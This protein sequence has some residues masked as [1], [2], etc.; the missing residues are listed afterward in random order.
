MKK[1]LILSTFFLSTILLNTGFAQSKYIDSLSIVLAK[2]K[3]DTSRVSVLADLGYFHRYQNLDTAMA[4]C[5]KAILLAQQIKFSKGESKAYQILGVSYRL[6][7][8]LA[9]SLELLF[10]ALKIAE[11]NNYQEEIAYSQMRIAIV[12]FDL[13]E[14]QKS[15]NAIYK[16]LQIFGPE[17]QIRINA[18]N[19][20]Q[21][22]N[23]YER[24]N[25]LDSAWYYEKMAYDNLDLIKDL[26]ADVC[27]ALG[28]IQLRKG[29]IP[30]ALKYYRESINSAELQKDY[31]AIS[32][33]YSEIAK[34]Y[35]KENQL[36]SSVYY[37]KNGLD[38]AQRSSN[39]RGILTCGSLLAEI[40]ESSNPPEA[41]RYYKIAAEAKE[42]LFGAGNLLTIQALVAK[43]EERKNEIEFAR[44]AYQA[45]LKQY[46][47]LAGLGVFVIVALILYKNNL[48]RQKSNSLLQKQKSE[49]EIQ[50]RNV[51]HALANLKST[52][53]QLIQSEKMAS[54]GELTAGIAHEIQNPLN[55]VNNFSEVSAELVKEMMDEVEK[56]NTS[57]VKAIAID[58]V[59]NLEKINHHGKRADAIVKGMLQHSQKGSGHKEAANINALADEYLRLAYHGLR[60]KDDSFNATMKTDFD[61]KIGKVNIVPQE[62]GRVILN[63]INN[64]FYAVNEKSKLA[65]PDYEPTVWLET[66]RKEDK[67]EITVR[68]NGNGIP[69]KIK[70]KIFQ[71]F[72]TTKP[73]GQ[74]T[75]LGLSLSYDIVKAHG[76]ELRVQ[77]LSAEEAAQAGKEVEGSEFIIQ[78]P[79]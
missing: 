68:D 74:G 73:T 30:L 67:V 54:L 69:H 34:M 63:L 25:Q 55:F 17:K 2:A 72:F 13:N 53:A 62:I 18:I 76:G 39:K 57:E 49:I 28:T 60:A 4:F 20:L 35:K 11:E 75:G 16:S 29:N 8:D 15:I 1:I 40:F 78:I 65:N 77:T 50:K 79:V 45:Q 33:A 61:P 41:L 44:A 70:E 12:Y 26:T 10:K 46:G 23:V 27:R 51:D 36:D 38:Y 42:G 47:L 32:L 14:Y 71:P 52:Q 64:A 37:A 58:V 21:L 3:D 9:K 59:Q 31:R 66:K 5:Q 19:Y 22:G 56:G 24:L 48:S 43:E 6:R 7:G